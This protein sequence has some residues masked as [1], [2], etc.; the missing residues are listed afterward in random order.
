MEKWDIEECSDLEG[1][2]KVMG[3]NGRKQKIAQSWE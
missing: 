1:K 2:V 3:K